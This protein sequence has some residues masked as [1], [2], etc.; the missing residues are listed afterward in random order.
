[1]YADDLLLISSSIAHLK[2]LIDI[3]ISEFNL[4]DLAING[5]K[6]GCI[7]FGVNHSNVC[8]DLFK[9]DAPFS[10]TDCLSYLGNTLISAKRFSVDLKPVLVKLYRSFIAI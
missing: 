6:S 1:M 3:C 10:W 4:L 2:K 8:N 9:R 5:K 7:R